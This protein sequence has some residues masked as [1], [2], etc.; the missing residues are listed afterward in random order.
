[1]AKGPQFE[2]DVCRQLSLWWSD[3]NREDIFWRTQNSGGR[4]TTRQKSGKKTFGQ[5][6]DIM[7][8][9]P[10]GQPLINL[11]TFELKR[12][13]SKDSIQDLID[14]KKGPNKYKEWIEKIIKTSEL[15]GSKYWVLIVRRNAR[16]SLLF[17]SQKFER[18]LSKI[19]QNG[20]DWKISIDCIT[21]ESIIPIY[22]IE[23]DCFLEY[24]RPSHI[25][26]CVRKEK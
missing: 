9:D 8:T 23:L 1:M 4:A 20:I 3:N 14:R 21:K 12:G 17:T 2:R 5:Y 26:K 25:Y 13:Y 11:I 24:V 6:G 18:D 22:G 15:A 10:C 19:V 16:I 7:A